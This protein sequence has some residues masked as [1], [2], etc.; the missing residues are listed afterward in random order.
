[1]RRLFVACCWAGLVGVMALRAKRNSI[2]LIGSAQPGCWNLDEMVA[3]VT[4]GASNDSEKALAL[5]RFGRAHLIH[6]MGPMEDRGEFITDPLKLIAV[7]GYAICGNNNCAMSGLYNAAGLK[8]RQRSMP[9]HAVPEV[10]FD[11]KWNYIDTDMF[12]YVF[13]P[14]GQHLASVD[15]LAQNPKLFLQQAHPPD[16]YFPFDE[17]TTMVEASSTGQ[18]EKDYHPYANA[19]LMNLALRSGESVRLFYRPQG[20]ERCF[21]PQLPQKDLGIVYKDS[22]P[23]GPVRRESLAWCD[24][25]PASYDNG[26]FEYAP[27]LRSEAFERENPERQGVAVRKAEDRPSLSAAVPH[28]PASLNWLKFEWVD[29]KGTGRVGLETLGL[30]T[31]VD[32]SPMALPRVATGKNIFHFSSRPLRAIYNHSRWDRGQGLPEQKLE[33]LKLSGDTPCLRQ[34]D[35]THPGSPSFPVGNGRAARRTDQ[36]PNVVQPRAARRRYRGRAGV[37]Q[38]FNP[39]LR[40]GAG[41]R[42]SD[43]TCCARGS[44]WP[45]DHT[46]LERERPDPR[47]YGVLAERSGE[48][49]VH[50]GSRTGSSQPGATDRVREIRRTAL[51]K[52]RFVRGAGRVWSY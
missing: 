33:N 4:K 21:L 6:F 45:A 17:K 46:R 3:E 14:D 7:Y 47:R 43:S 44:G 31:W 2:R 38:G 15:E 13:L 49:Q 12:G 40:P 34:V 29:R 20:S 11:G 28:Q 35:P 37:A 18:A 16:P 10:W 30:R 41:D 26:L 23:D 24:T 52:F 39:R 27:D 9:G 25:P 8:A 19:H 5:H 50:G 22:D 42:E 48:R 32:L 1:M 36:E 51:K